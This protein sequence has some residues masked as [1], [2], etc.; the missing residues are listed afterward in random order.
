MAL[1]LVLESAD[2][3]L[4]AGPALSPKIVVKARGRSWKGAPGVTG[5]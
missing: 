4:D 3:G 2:A 5:K 1:E